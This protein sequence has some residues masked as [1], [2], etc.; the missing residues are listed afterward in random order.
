[1]V[2]ASSDP[3]GVELNYDWDALGRLT[4]ISPSYPELPTAVTYVGLHETS[5]RQEISTQNFIESVYLYDELGRV[6][7]EQ[8]RNLEGGYDFRRTEY[9]IGGQVTRQSEWAPEGSSEESLEWTT[10]EY[11]TF[12][13]PNAGE[14]DEPATFRDPLGRVTKVVQPDGS[15][16]ETDY[17]GLVTTVTMHGVEGLEGPISSTTVYRNDPFGRLAEVDSPDDGADAIYEYDDSDRLIQVNCDPIQRR[18]TE[19][20]SVDSSNTTLWAGCAGPRTRKTGRW[21]TWR[22]MP[23]ASC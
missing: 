17:D 14:Q 16:T 20:S 13:N 6:I 2:L 18:E 8:K 22:T 3:A 12:S 23:G 7:E 15:I 4:E 19:A 5:V 9:D 21:T 11:G 10:Y 1:M